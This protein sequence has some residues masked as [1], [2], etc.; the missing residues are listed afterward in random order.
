M[1]FHELNPEII[2]AS[3]LAPPSCSGKN[4]TAHLIFVDIAT[5]SSSGSFSRFAR[6]SHLPFTHI[7]TECWIT[8]NYITYS[9]ITSCIHISLYS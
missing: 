7:Y 1:G 6:P 5:P 8:I 9:Q 4:F 3:R 2:A